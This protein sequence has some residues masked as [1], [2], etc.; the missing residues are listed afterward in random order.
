VISINRHG[1]KFWRWDYTYN[2]DWKLT[3]VES[4]RYN[5]FTFDNFELNY[6]S[7]GRLIRMYDYAPASVTLGL[8][9]HRFYYDNNNH[10]IKIQSNDTAVASVM[11]YH[12]DRLVSVEYTDTFEIPNRLNYLY[13]DEHTILLEVNQRGVHKYT[14]SFQSGTF[15]NPYWSVR[16]PYYTDP[17]FFSEFAVENVTI[18]YPDGSFV[19]SNY[20][21]EDDNGDGYPER[22]LEEDDDTLEFSYFDPAADV[23]PIFF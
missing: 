10:I 22:R 19:G 8:N 3:I 12:D 4:G 15:K 2:E 6:D 16:L 7:R 9:P 17:T 20:V 1:E 23:E 5:L 18:T 13:P 21:F 11:T 14:I